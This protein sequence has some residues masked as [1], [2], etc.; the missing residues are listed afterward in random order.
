[1]TARTR[2]ELSLQQQARNA[3][4]KAT[5][6]KEHTHTTGVFL[7]AP[8]HTPQKS[9][10]HLTA[11]HSR[12]PSSLSS[13]CKLCIYLDN[14]LLVVDFSVNKELYLIRLEALGFPVQDIMFKI[15]HLPK[16]A[17]KAPQVPHTLPHA[18]TPTSASKAL[19]HATRPQPPALPP[20]LPSEALQ[21]RTL[22]SHL[23]Q[24]LQPSAQKAIENTLRAARLKATHKL[25]QS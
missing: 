22:T 7:I 8:K 23:P 1:M 15:S 25:T 6:D 13:A 11:S 19:H 3:W 20:L 10:S 2:R 21:A 4:W 18:H 9:I 5:G 12:K 14:E 24:K 16:P 17:Q